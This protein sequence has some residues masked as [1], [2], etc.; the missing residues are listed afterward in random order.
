M[1]ARAFY[2]RRESLGAPHAELLELAARIEDAA[3]DRA[4]AAR[5]RQRAQDQFPAQTAPATEGSR[6][7]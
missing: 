6:Q 4:A 1:S 5:Y 7:P 3:G 2:Q